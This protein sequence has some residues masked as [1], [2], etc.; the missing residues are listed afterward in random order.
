MFDN[1]NQK[2]YSLEDNVNWISYNV[3]RIAD[4]IETYLNEVHNIDT[5]KKNNNYKGRQ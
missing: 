1:Q 3:R 2:E 4:L 5:K